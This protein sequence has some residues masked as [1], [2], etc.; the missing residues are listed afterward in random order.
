LYVNTD[1]GFY[2]IEGNKARLFSNNFIQFHSSYG[3]I[4]ENGQYFLHNGST[5]QPTIITDEFN[6]DYGRAAN[7]YLIL[8]HNSLAYY[9]DFTKN[10]AVEL[11]KEVGGSGLSFFKNDTTVLGYG[12]KSNSLFYNAVFYRLNSDYQ[13]VIETIEFENVRENARPSFTSYKNEG[14]L[15]NSNVI[16]IMDDKQKFEKLDKVAGDPNRAVSVVKNGYFYFVAFDKKYGRQVYRIQAKSERKPDAVYAEKS[17]ALIFYPNP[18]TTSLYING[19]DFNDSKVQI[20]TTEGKC[21]STLTLRNNMLDISFLNNGIYILL[22]EKGSKK[23]V[24]KVVKVSQ[25]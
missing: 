20:L 21:I 7:G 18:A 12:I 24:G 11:P 10:N 22:I 15:Y 14:L 13:S 8:Y 23:W 17:T 1:N 9:Y 25:E 4:V 16:Y 19:E 5:L 3:F 6:I 2:K